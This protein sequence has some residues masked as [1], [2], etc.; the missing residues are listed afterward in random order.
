VTN[1]V[2]RV[3][4][5]LALAPA[6]LGVVYLGGWWVFG[7][8]TLAAAIALH[9]YW[10]MARQ[11]RPLAPAGYIGAILGLVGAQLGGA[12][13]LLGGV[14]VTLVLAFALKVIS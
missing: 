1:A 8:A 4:I 9:E 10:L 11:L 13:W 5:A 2:S 6:V 3:L 14:M 12:V 7:L